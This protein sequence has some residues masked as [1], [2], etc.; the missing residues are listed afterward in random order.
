MQKQG[1][2]PRLVDFTV[3]DDKS[4]KECFTRK[5]LIDLLDNILDVQIEL[6]RTRFDSLG[7]SIA[8][9][10]SVNPKYYNTHE[11]L[12]FNRGLRLWISDD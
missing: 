10:G 3:L 2:K 6:V 5:Q 8:S 7:I 12:G 11:N 9:T 1:R 4:L